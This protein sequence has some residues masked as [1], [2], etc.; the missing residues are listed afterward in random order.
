MLKF[1][2]INGSDITNATIQS[3]QALEAYGYSVDYLSDVLDSTTYVA[4]STGVSVDD[5]MKKA[6][7]GAPQI[8][9]L[10]LEFDEAV[11]LIGQLEQHG[12]DSSAALSGMTK[13]AGS[14]P[15]K[16]RP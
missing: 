11:T 15:S 14:T 4:Q 7:D 5:L 3:K 2:E 8:K 1:A 12:V 16:E 13:A 6:T 9:M 10:G